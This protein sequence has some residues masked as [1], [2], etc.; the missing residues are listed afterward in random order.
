MT[1]KDLPKDCRPRE[2]LLSKGA[3]S[4]SDSELL[5]IFLRTGV[6]GCSAIELAA[7]LINDFGSLRGLFN[8][9]E[10]QFT[11]GKGLGRA[12]YVQ[13]QAVLEMSS[14]YLSEL[15]VRHDAFTSTQDTARY[16][17][18]KL[19]DKVRETF[20]VLFLDNQHRLIKE[21]AL[22][23]GTINAAAVYPRDVVKRALE[24]HAN[25]LILCH[26]HPSGIAE[27]SNADL[28]ITNRIKEALSLIDIRL[29]DHLI[30]GDAEVVSFAERG[31]I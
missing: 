14:R 15:M 11:Q 5:A 8:A 28:Q 26:N 21:E 13:L 9:S 18:S 12:K 27:P 19:R 10:E 1:L 29:L 25:A 30:V 17:R 4:L 23:H 2:K 16:L 22:F 24:L 3:E 7:Q 31:L 20:V 6:K